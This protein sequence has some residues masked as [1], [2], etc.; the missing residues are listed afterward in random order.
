MRKKEEVRKMSGDPDYPAEDH[1]YDEDDRDP[2]E[3]SDDYG[4]ESSP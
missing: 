4:D 3:H 1:L 2:E